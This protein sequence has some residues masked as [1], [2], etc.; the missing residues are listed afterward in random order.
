MEQTCENNDQRFKKEDAVKQ[1]KEG[2]V[3]LLLLKDN[4]NNDGKT[5]IHTA[6]H[7][8]EIDQD[9]L[10]NNGGDL[11]FHNLKPNRIENIKI[12]FPNQ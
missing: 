11:S 1:N 9:S 10:T 4:N 3:I 8:Q 7:K 12:V 5:R 6:V 2:K